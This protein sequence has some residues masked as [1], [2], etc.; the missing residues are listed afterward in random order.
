MKE[1][2]QEYGRAVISVAVAVVLLLLIFGNVK[3]GEA[4]G[5][6]AI[7]AGE[8]VPE[9][10]NFSACLDTDSSGAYMERERPGIDF[11]MWDVKTGLEYAP[12]E[13]FAAEDANGNSA[14]VEVMEILDE[15]TQE[16]EAT[17][18][19]MMFAKQGIY[20]VRVK[21]IDSYN[22]VTENVFFVPVK[23]G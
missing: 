2:M 23:R 4:K 15:N 12:E 6:P 17:G 1:I 22:C 13:L 10:R 16:V 21:A 18:G 20:Q 5:L 8:A 11:F 14:K 19:K 7:L 3:A 9:G